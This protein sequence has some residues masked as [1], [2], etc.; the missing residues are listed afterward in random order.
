MKSKEASDKSLSLLL[1]ALSSL[2]LLL[3][4]FS[5]LGSPLLAA[6]AL[7]LLFRLGFEKKW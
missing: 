7:P 2:L 3:L 4:S 5:E 1:L 6:E